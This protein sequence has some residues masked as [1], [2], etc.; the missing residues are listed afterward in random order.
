MYTWQ[1]LVDQGM[2]DISLH[3]AWSILAPCIHFNPVGFPAIQ[4]RI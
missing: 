1:E 4:K 3:G 2:V